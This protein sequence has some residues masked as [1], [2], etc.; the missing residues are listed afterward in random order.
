M[1]RKAPLS[2]IG[3]KERKVSDYVPSDAVHGYNCFG[4][5]RYFLVCLVGI[6]LALA[7]SRNA[8]AF[9]PVEPMQILLERLFSPTTLWPQDF[10]KSS[11][12]AVK[13]VN[14]SH[15]MERHGPLVTRLTDGRIVVLNGCH[16]SAAYP[17]LYAPHE[18]VKVGFVRL[19]DVVAE[20]DNSFA[21]L[22]NH[23]LKPNAPSVVIEFPPSP[24][25]GGQ[26]PQLF[27]QA[28]AIVQQQKALLLELE[29]RAVRNPCYSQEGISFE[30]LLRDEGVANP[31]DV[32]ACAA[33]QKT[34]FVL[35]GLQRCIPSATGCGAGVGTGIL[36]DLGTTEGLVSC[37]VDREEAQHWGGGTG[38]AA[39]WMAGEGAA[40]YVGGTSFYSSTG[41][42]GLAISGPGAALATHTHIMTKEICPNT[43]KASAGCQENNFQPIGNPY[44][45]KMNLNANR[46][47]AEIL[48][49]LNSC[50]GLGSIWFGIKYWTGFGPSGGIGGGW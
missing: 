36:V 26:T 28:P 11:F 6:L 1:F 7:A 31:A 37:G 48:M 34:P 9:P 22:K 43:L 35:R 23:R 16:T 27:S 8:S 46:R 19:E 39:G 12:V 32:P 25:S 24:W 10:V 42:G 41:L 5:G 29:N 21:W 45:A 17:Y 49:E 33:Q 2:V 15:G 14:I 30:S 38:F 18:Q 13:A 50:A 3:N 20:L 47:D 44:L 40:A 4:R